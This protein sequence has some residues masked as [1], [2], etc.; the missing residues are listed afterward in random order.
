MAESDF[1]NNVMRCRCK[2]D[3]H[4]AYMYGCHA[5]E[6]TKN[7]SVFFSHHRNFQLSPLSNDVVPLQVMH[8]VQKLKTCLSIRG[9]SPTTFCNLSQGPEGG[10]L[11]WP[12]DH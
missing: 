8:I 3:G 1:M 5:G 2:Y 10:L 7:L 6:D 12:R 9:K 4:R 11:M